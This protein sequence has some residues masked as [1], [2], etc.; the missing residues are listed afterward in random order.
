MQILVIKTVLI[1]FNLGL[2]IVC[3][4]WGTKYGSDYVNKL[5]KGFKRNLNKKFNFF[6]IT[7]NTDNLDSEIRTMELECEFKG[8]MKKSVLFNKKCKII[9]YFKDTDHLSRRIM[10]IDL[11]MIVVGNLDYLFDYNG[12]FCLMKTDDIQCESSK[13]GYNSSIILW[14]NGFGKEIYSTLLKYHD[15]ITKQIV[16][17]DHYLEFLIKNSD[18][19]GDCFPSK[20]LDY[21]FYCKG[22]TQLPTECTIVAFPRSP[23]PH[24]C[25]EEFLMKHW[26]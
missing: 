25:T 9:I 5:Y 4:K 24:E 14:K 21:N 18:F 15:Y 20:I 11:D 7:D 6:C 2:S 16:R 13:N 23:K 1:L 17:F 12:D 26:I 22:K 8:W 19:T 10:F 3:I